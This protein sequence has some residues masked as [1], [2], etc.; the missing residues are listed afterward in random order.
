MKMGPFQ[1]IQDHSPWDSE[2]SSRPRGS[3]DPPFPFFSHFY[4]SPL[5]HFLSAFPRHIHC[6]PHSRYLRNPP[7]K[8]LCFDPEILET[9]EMFHPRT[10]TVAAGG[11]LL[12]DQA[13]GAFGAGNVCYGEPLVV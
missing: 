13:L 4:S 3:T 12:C 6:P 1:G 10:A 5:P 7:L 8:F 2:S 11:A 9:R